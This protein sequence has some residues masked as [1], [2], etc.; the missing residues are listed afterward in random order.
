MQKPQRNIVEIHVGECKGEVTVQNLKTVSEFILS[1]AKHSTI[2]LKSDFSTEINQQFI[3]FLTSSAIE[4]DKDS[5]LDLL[6]LFNA[7]KCKKLIENSIIFIKNQ[8]SIIDVFKNYSFVKE[9]LNVNPHFGSPEFLSNPHSTQYRR[10][11]Q[12]S[13]QKLNENESP[14]MH[15]QKMLIDSITSPQTI[16][17]DDQFLKLPVPQVV[18][19]FESR[20]HSELPQSLVFA[21]ILKEI[22]IHKEQSEPL[23]QF[24]DYNKL[25]I[26]QLTDLRDRLNEN[27]LHSLAYLIIHIIRI[28]TLTHNGQQMS[29]FERAISSSI[30]FDVKYS[31]GNEF[32]GVFK[33]LN[34]SFLYGDAISNGYVILTTSSNDPSMIIGSNN[35]KKSNIWRS[36]NEQ[37][38]FFSV[39]THD[40]IY[41]NSYSY[42]FCDDLVPESYA[43][44]KSDDQITWE[45][46]D[47][48]F[49]ESSL[50]KLTNELDS[51][52]RTVQGNR[53][54][55]TKKL[56]QL[57]STKHVRLISLGKNKSG[58]NSIALKSF[59]LYQNNCS[60]L[61]PMLN[62]DKAKIVVRPS[63]LGLPALIEQ[64]KSAF[65]ISSN[66]KDSFLQISFR[67]FC[68]V[69]TGYTLKTYNF[70]KNMNHLKNWTLYGSL[71]SNSWFA[72]DIVRDNYDLNAPSLFKYFKCM[73]PRPCRYIKLQIDG[74]NHHDKHVLALSGIELFGMIIPDI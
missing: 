63:S 32:N 8:I 11:R 16:I 64:T 60:I 37:N 21:F 15:F 45:T 4:F 38:P 51:M 46:I 34:R 25:I 48:T 56:N 47:Q 30:T 35:Q 74:P 41:F 28:K 65:W 1:H 31:T 66:K 22:E 54:R 55:K 29:P 17:F 12:S 23:L 26:P 71:D 36:A 5:I 33:M 9:Q 70:I 19:I 67:S 42:S 39:S 24:L 10:T 3:S 62:M 50:T 44:Q 69:V 13:L 20:S 7:Y 40:I 68:V 58:S 18:S 73:N 59:E 14:L 72:L 52:V 2:Y 27:N 6:I 53:E 61:R 49:M 43:L 57:V